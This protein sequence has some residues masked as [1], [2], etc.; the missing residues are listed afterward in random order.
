[1]EFTKINNDI[2]GNP[3][4]VVHFYEL[5]NDGEGEGLNILEKF[6]LVVKKARKIGGKMYRGKDFGG[7]IVFQSYDIQTTINK[8]KGI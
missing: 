8:A 2:N 7:G 5:L 1:M 4:F 6:D 3:R